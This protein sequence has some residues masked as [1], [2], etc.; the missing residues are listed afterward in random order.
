VKFDSPEALIEHSGSLCSLPDIYFQ[1][2]Q[3][4][5]DPNAS[6]ERIGEVISLDAALSARLLRI[7][8]SPYYG[9]AAR[10]DTVSR[11]IAV[12]GVDDLYN[13]AVATCVMDRF[14]K[15]PT[16]LLDMSAYWKN[17]M[18]TGMLSQ[19]LAKQCHILHPERLFIAGLLHDLGSLLI[20]QHMPEF[21]KQILHESGNDRIGRFA[22]EYALLGYSHADISAKLL[23]NWGLPESLHLSIA[24]YPRPD[25]AQT[26]K[27]ESYLLHLSVYL[28]NALAC[29]ANLIQVIE[30]I[31]I[32]TL[33]FLRLSPDVLVNCADTVNQEFCAVYESFSQPNKSHIFS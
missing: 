22:S 26:Y 12:V 20:F 9:Y 1:L 30:Q 33:A 15:I 24:Q 19:K 6:L 11:A 18:M 23:K 14:A 5:Q 7:V 17:N 4:L 8:N 21:G 16:D 29:Q 31:D 25:T 13:M 10:I 28:I 3:L 27:L 32:N 2:N